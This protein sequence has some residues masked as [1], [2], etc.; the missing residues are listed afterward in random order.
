MIVAPIGR[1]KHFRL[2]SFDRLHRYVAGHSAPFALTVAIAL[3]NESYRVVVVGDT[4]VFVWKSI[5]V[6]Y[7]LGW[8]AHD[9]LTVNLAARIK[10]VILMICLQKTKVKFDHVVEKPLRHIEIHLHLLIEGSKDDTLRLF[11]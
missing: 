2:P 3:L 8:V 4:E 11:I 1:K 5:S 7:R 10:T 6:I 9:C